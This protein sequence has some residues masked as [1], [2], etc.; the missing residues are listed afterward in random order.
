MKSVRLFP[1]IVL[2]VLA[3]MAGCKTD[4]PASSDNPN[5]ASSGADAKDAKEAKKEGKGE[6]GERPAE[7]HLVI[8]AGTSISVRLGQALSSKDSQAG[9][10]FSASVSE[11]VTVDGKTVIA[12]GAAAH[13]KVVDAKAMGHFK[14]GALLHVTLDSVAVGGKEEAI[15]TT[16]AGSTLKGKGKRSTIAIAGGAG[17]G[18]ALGGIFGGGKGAAIG[19]AAGAGAGT[20]G[21]AFTGNKEIVFPAESVL[22]FKL[23]DPLEVH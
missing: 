21:A 9:E 3:F 1:A 19:A 14:G 22:T 18:A 12:D 15:V 11:P 5:G 8:P 23:K 17:L 16:A 6:R 20:A 4:A 2:V 7:R 13:G 10:G